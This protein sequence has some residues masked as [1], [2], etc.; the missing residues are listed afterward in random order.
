MTLF[1]DIEKSVP[2]VN[3]TCRTCVHRQPVLVGFEE[4]QAITKELR[5]KGIEAYSCDLQ[6][7]SGGHSEWHLQMDIFPHEC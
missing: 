7:C 6:E 2:Q 5:A 1:D 3:E 4:S